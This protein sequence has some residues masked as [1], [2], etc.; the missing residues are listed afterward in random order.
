MSGMPALDAV[1][2]RQHCLLDDL[3]LFLQGGVKRD[4]GTPIEVVRMGEYQ[5]TTRTP[6]QSGGL[7][8]GKGHLGDIAFF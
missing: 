8:E 5:F 1:N 6:H 4:K 7:R 3:L 2:V